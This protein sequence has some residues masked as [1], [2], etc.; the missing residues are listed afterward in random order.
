[1]Q[2]EPNLVQKLGAEFIGTALLVLIGAGSVTATVTLEAGTKAPFSEADLGI[3]S[4]A[5]GFIIIAMVYSIGKISGCHINPAVTIALLLTGRV[6]PTTA[7]TYIV[8]QFAGAIAGAFGIVAVFGT[9]AASSSILGVTSYGASVSPAQAI[10]AE[11]IGTF[12]LVFTIYGVAV[13]P[14]SPVGWAGL[15]IGLIVAGI[16]FVVAPVTG[17][18]LNP[19]RAFGTTFV[20][21]LFG[22]KD[23]Y[24]QYYVYAV[25]PIVGGALGGIAYD[26]LAR[27]RAAAASAPAEEPVAERG[28]E[29]VAAR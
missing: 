27:P 23:F 16:I 10:V 28:R 9:Q 1:M 4:F 29:R 24:D 26:V 22:G 6:G 8:A 19:A 12:I 5:F 14:R 15:V 7:V 20:Q 21:A 17:A 25:G 2:R 13:D 18:A 11:A 3:I